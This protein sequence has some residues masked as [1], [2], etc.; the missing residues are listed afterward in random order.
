MSCNKKEARCSYG[1]I[2][3]LMSYEQGEMTH[4]IRYERHDI[5]R[6]NGKQQS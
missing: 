2:E 1:L 3:E 5:T 6:Q 4:D